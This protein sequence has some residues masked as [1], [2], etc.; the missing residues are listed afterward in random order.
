MNRKHA[1][2]FLAAIIGDYIEN[3]YPLEHLVGESAGLGGRV[4]PDPE[5]VR[6][7]KL[8]LEA[9]GFERPARHLATRFDL[10]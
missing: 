2:E 8:A 4:F 3:G 7:L 5:N 9:L 10:P 1:A 6:S